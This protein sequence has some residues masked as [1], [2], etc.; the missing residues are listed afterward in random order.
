MRALFV[1]RN[2]RTSP[3]EF[4]LYRNKKL[5]FSF[6]HLKGWNKKSNHVLTVYPPD[7]IMVSGSNQTIAS[8]CI[9]MLVSSGEIIETPSQFYRSFLIEQRKRY[10]EYRLLWDRPARLVSGEPAYEWSFEFDVSTARFIAVYCIAT[11]N[12]R[13]KNLTLLLNGACLKSQFEELEPTFL[14]VVRSLSFS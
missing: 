6:E 5:G 9:T 12:I 2:K 8:P 10:T 11:K 4:V 1:R 7:A 14:K 3:S 13:S